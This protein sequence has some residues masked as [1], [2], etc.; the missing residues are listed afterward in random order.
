MAKEKNSFIYIEEGKLEYCFIKEKETLSLK[1]NEVLYIPKLLPY[2]VRYLKDN[3]II[4]IM[5]FDILA[6]TVP[7]HLILP[8]RKKSR[9]F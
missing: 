6:D 4:K 3:T 1:K 5:Q 9:D 2:T 8:L 7:G